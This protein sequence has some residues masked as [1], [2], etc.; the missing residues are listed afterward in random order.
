MEIF[1]LGKAKY[2]SQI[3]VLIMYFV[4]Y[5]RHTKQDI[6]SSDIDSVFLYCSTLTRLSRDAQCEAISVS[7]YQNTTT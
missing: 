6:Q 4:K 2:H 7:A 5:R 3:F 1:A